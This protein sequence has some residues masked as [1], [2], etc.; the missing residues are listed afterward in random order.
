LINRAQLKWHSYSEPKHAKSRSMSFLSMPSM[1]VTKEAIQISIFAYLLGMASINGLYPFALSFMAANFLYR[2]DYIL[3]GLFSFL[4]TLTAMKSI[5]SLR[6]LGAMGLF[7]LMYNL[8]NRLNRQNEF[9]FGMTIFFSNVLAGMVFLMTRG[10]SPYDMFLL[11]IESGM[12]SIMTFIIA[13]GMPWIFKEPIQAAER[14][15]CMAVLAGVILSIARNFICLGMN[16]RD[17]LGVFFV[18]SMALVDGPGAGA[19]T[20]I[21]IGITGF[22]FSLSPWSTAIMAFSG[23]VSGSFNK[24]GKIGVITGFSLGY[25]LYNF[26]VNSMGEIIIPPL[27]LVTSYILFLLLPQKTIRMMQLYLSNTYGTNQLATYNLEE[28]ARDRLHELA[29]L[30]NDLSGAFKEPFIKNEERVFPAD[31]LD[32][33]CGEAQLTICSTCG[34]RRI[35][36]EK[37]L[38]RT[39]GAFYTLIKHHEG[40]YDNKELPFLFRSRCGQTEEIKKIVKDKSNLFKVKHQMDNIIQCNQELMR[41]HFVKTADM[42]KALAEG[43]WEE[44]YD[45]NIDGELSEKLSQLGVGVDRIYTD[46]N[47]RRFYVNIVKSPC[48]NDKQCDM[49]IPLAVSDVLGRKIST[50]II[51]CPLKSGNSKCRLKITSEGIL[52]VSVGAAGVA[53]EGQNVSG[54]SFSFMEF[55]E[56]RYMLA[57]CDGMGVGKTA[58]QHSEKTL[59]MLECLLEAGYSQETALK[60]TNSV[61][62]ATNAD[63]GFSTAD[64]A[65]INTAIGKIKFIKAGAPVGFVKRGMKAEMIKGGS[66]PVGIMDEILPKITEKTVRSGDM[67]IMVTDGVIDAFS[68]GENGEEMLRRF[69]IETRTANPQE[70]AERILKKAKEKNSIK[71]DMTALVASIWEQR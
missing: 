25:F 51:D 2:R 50:K 54:D 5:V 67:V 65:L 71:D 48:I 69:L 39:M 35:C 46:Y 38:K 10:V 11:I 43:V 32:S 29:S 57:L 56:G 3:P 27:V 20:G 44:T 47:N 41:G 30:L 8:L 19:A 22:S 1:P 33:V 55:K 36:W 52:E 59:T 21:I 16:V 15:I 62:I 4:G 61:M 70:M 26:Y 17:V 34:M 14:N 60:V 12:A 66:L 40:L 42:V 45:R 63:E 64:I 13:G 28:R 31:Y 18:L 9:R 24:L 6:Y 58:A 53:K 49:L 37:E 23:L 7:L 68:K